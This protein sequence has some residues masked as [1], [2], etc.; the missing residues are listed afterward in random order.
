M[1]NPFENPFV[2]GQDQVN[3]VEDP[4]EAEARMRR[5]RPPSSY[6]K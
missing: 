5:K 4:E 6:R 2:G 3:N 1:Q